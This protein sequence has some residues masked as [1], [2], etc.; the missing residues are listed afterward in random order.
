MQGKNDVFDDMNKRKIAMSMMSYLEE[1]R[2]FQDK[3]KT[4]EH[5][6]SIGS[7]ASACQKKSRRL[8]V[9]EL[10]ERHPGVGPGILCRLFGFTGQGLWKHC[11]SHLMAA[12]QE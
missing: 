11:Q 12:F 1:V 6:L 10:K 5:A 3:L 9:R 8:T 7:L 4:L 2:M